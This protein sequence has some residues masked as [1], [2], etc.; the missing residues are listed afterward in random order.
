[1]LILSTSALPGKGL[2]ER[3]VKLLGQPERILLAESSLD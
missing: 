2:F 1:M 3:N